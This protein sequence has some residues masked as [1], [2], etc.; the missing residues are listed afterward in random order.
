M[1]ALPCLIYITEEVFLHF[2][3]GWTR[4]M[5]FMLTH[6]YVTTFQGHTYFEYPNDVQS[7][8]VNCSF[9][10]SS[11]VVTVNTIRLT[12]HISLTAFNVQYDSQS[13]RALS[14]WSVLIETQCFL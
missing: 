3:N 8:Y 11:K 9:N 10:L 13:Y 4:A 12:C 5:E 2:E 7:Y 14:H 1:F 6:S